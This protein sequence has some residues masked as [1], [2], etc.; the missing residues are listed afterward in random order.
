M[1]GDLPALGSLG[2]ASGFAS[3]LVLALYIQSPI[4]A[5]N[6]ARPEALWSICLLLLYW[7]GRMTL[8]ANR[9]IVDD[10]P[11]VFAMGD[12]TSWLTGIG[13]LAAFLVA[14]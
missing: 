8:L 2:A 1:A 12:P 9:G 6:Y 10:D 7:L 4:V 3:V 11:L 13:I 5:E 14:L